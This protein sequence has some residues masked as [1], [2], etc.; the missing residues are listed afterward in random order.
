MTD[1][2]CVSPPPPPPDSQKYISGSCKSTVRLQDLLKYTRLAYDTCVNC[3]KVSLRSSV[4]KI[5]AITLELGA[6]QLFFL[7]HP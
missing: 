3:V 4:M 6:T 7:A 2:S 5:S 1:G